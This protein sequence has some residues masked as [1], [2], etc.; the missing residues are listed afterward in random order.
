MPDFLLTDPPDNPRSVKAP[1]YSNL[2]PVPPSSIHLPQPLAR[3]RTSRLTPHHPAGKHV[4]NPPRASALAVL[5]ST[6]HRLRASSCPL[7]SH[8]PVSTRAAWVLTGGPEAT[9]PPMGAVHELE[10]SAGGER[11]QLSGCPTLRF[12]EPLIVF[13]P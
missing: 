5:R 6:N 4:S 3:R 1:S 11:E 2:R 10:M 8:Q 7:R 12:Q 9:S 13:Y